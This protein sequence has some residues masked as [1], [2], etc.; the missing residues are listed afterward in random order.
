MLN[1]GTA[2][3][4]SIYLYDMN[5]CYPLKSHTDTQHKSV[6]MSAFLREYIPFKCMYM[7]EF[8]Y[9]RIMSESELHVNLNS[10]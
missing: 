9:I 7:C 3:H 8:V 10:S 1:N 6:P 5:F 4:T 2:N